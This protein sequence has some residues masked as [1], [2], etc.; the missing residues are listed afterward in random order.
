MSRL[1]YLLIALIL[2]LVGQRW[3]TDGGIPRDSLIVFLI[4]GILFAIAARAPSP[5]PS[6]PLRRKWQY[7]GIALA[8]IALALTAIASIQFWSGTYGGWAFWLWLLAIPIFLFGAWLD[9][10]SPDPET[11]ETAANAWLD[12][13]LDRRVALLLLLGI[14]LVAAAIRFYALDVYP[15][16]CQSDECNNG[17]DALK[18]LS[19]NYP[20]LPYAETNEGQATLFT[21][22]I[23]G[24]ITLFGQTVTSMRM[25]SA[26]VG[27]LTVV[28]VYFLA[29]EVYGQRLGL[30]TAALVAA[31]RWHL[32]FSRI[33]YEL[34]MMPLV[35]SLQTLFMIKALKS[36]RR[37]WWALSGLMLALG[38]NTYTAYRIVPA[39]IGVFFLYWLIAHRQRIRRDLEG[40]IIFAVGAVVGVAPLGVYIFRNWHVFISRINHISV[41]RD[42]EAA[43]SYAP[44]WSNLRKT[45]LMFNLQ[46]DFAALNNLPGAPLMQFVVAALLVLGVIWAIRWFWRELPFLYLVWFV[47]VASLAVLSVAHEAPTARRPIGLIPVIYLLAAAVFQQIWWAWSDAWGEKRWRPLAIALAALTVF[48]MLANINTYYRVQAVDPSVWAAYSPN[49][50]AVGEYLADVPPETRIY[51]SPQFTHHSAVHYIGGE[52]DIIPLNLGRHIPLREDPG[53]D[54]IFLL[55]TVDE[56]LIPLLQQLY[57]NGV[58]EVHRDRFDRSLFLTYSVPRFAFDEARGLQVGYSGGDSATPPMSGGQ[59]ATIDF[60]FSTSPPLAPPF[61]AQYDGALLVPQFGD[62]TLELLAEGGEGVLY[63]DGTEILRVQDGS[64]QVFRTMPGGF[65]GLRLDYETSE[66]PGRLQLRWTTPQNPQMSVIDA[67]SLYTVPGASNGLV[68]YYYATPDWSGTPSLIQR[69]LFILPNNALPRTL[70][71]P[72]GGQGSRAQRQAVMCSAHARMMARW[73]MW[74]AN[75][76]W[77]TAARTARNTA[78][79][80]SI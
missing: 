70:L 69:D 19:G 66:T 24:S 60:D 42:V 33:V 29:R 52:H 53:A 38:M 45:L 57:P 15:N 72:L 47:G 13:V 59:A 10:P 78:R 8:G 12:I 73:F 37:R 62:Y 2:A 3:L 23:A 34:I 65:H 36:G 40:M 55:E 43:G 76:W 63:L 54:V 27:T 68:G 18:W 31:D 80:L 26:L 74:M 4:A 46:G 41:F 50:S 75:W 5:W 79:A 51:M 35:L 71:D 39:F 9:L 32:T 16:G 22:L 21:Y 77:T 7:R 49:E 20:Y 1:I 44:L 48:V 61:T 28:A 64:E 67:A 17:L 11:E 56:R 14:I 30:I 58:Y 25:V 6:L